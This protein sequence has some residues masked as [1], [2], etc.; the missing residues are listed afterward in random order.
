MIWF[1][2]RILVVTRTG[3]QTVQRKE[4]D[5]LQ[6]PKKKKLFLRTNQNAC[7]SLFCVACKVLWKR[8]RCV[9]LLFHAFRLVR[10]PKASTCTQICSPNY[11]KPRFQVLHNWLPRFYGTVSSLRRWLWSSW[12]KRFLHL[13]NPE[14]SL[15][16]SPRPQCLAPQLQPTGPHSVPHLR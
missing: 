11:L 14:L 16:C 12:T 8:S 10:L 4:T 15:P 7:L 2:N 5:S 9:W 1:V 6:M 3:W 13:G